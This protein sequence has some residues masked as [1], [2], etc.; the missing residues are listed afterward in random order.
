MLDIKLIVRA[1]T[2]LS[3]L[4]YQERVWLREN[5]MSHEMSSLEETG[6]KLFND[7]GLDVAL[8]HEHVVF[9]LSL[10]EK[11][12]R[13]RNDLR[14]VYY[15]VHTKAELHSHRMDTIRQNAAEVL[16]ELRKNLASGTP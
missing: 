8:E 4:S 5:P 2:E 6:A 7:S 10:D 1:L 13:L 12:R 15:R 3:D 14:D 16:N 9:A 11:L